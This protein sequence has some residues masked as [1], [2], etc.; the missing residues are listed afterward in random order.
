MFLS[1]YS[2]ALATCNFSWLLPKVHMTVERKYFELT[3]GMEATTTVLLKTLMKA[4]Q[5]PLPKAAEIMGYVCSNLGE[6]G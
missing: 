3:Q 6:T 2:L 5:E 4:L 1:T